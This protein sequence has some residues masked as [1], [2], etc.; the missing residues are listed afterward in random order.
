MATQ[1][2]EA[3]SGIVN[4]VDVPQLTAIMDSM[5]QDPASAKCRFRARNVWQGGAHNR[6]SIHTF[7]VGGEEDTSREKPFEMSNDEPPVLLG[8]NIG[9]NPVEYVL[10]ALSGCLTTT[11]VYY[12]AVMGVQ[13][14]R[15]ESTLEGDL[16]LQGLFGL[17]DTVRRGYEN[18]RG[19]FKIDSP[20]PRAKLEELVQVAR[21]FSPV[22]DV[23]SNP[24]RV[25]VGLG[26]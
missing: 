6:V 2:I 3:T 11:L 14:D 12:G 22:C 1:T 16:D 24:V 19:T 17:D 15:V 21:N 9:P 26:V 20:A 13:L 25:G 8:E 4:G 5:R 7:D 10:T 23:V 18:V